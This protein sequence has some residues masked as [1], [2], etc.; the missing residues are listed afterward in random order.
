[1]IS[2]NS[3]FSPSFR[4]ASVMVFARLRPVVVILEI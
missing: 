1:M 4:P 3:P 2:N